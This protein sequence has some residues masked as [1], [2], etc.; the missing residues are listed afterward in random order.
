MVLIKKKKNSIYEWLDNPIQDLIILSDQQINIPTVVSKPV[1]IKA[2]KP[3][4]TKNII[5]PRAGTRS[6]SIKDAIEGKQS[7]VSKTES[8]ADND[9]DDDIDDDIELDFH[10]E[11]PIPITQIDIE[12]SWQLFI[13]EFLSTKPRYASLLS[14]YMPIVGEDSVVTVDLESQL[15]LDMFNEVK[16][17]LVLFLRKK[18]NNKLINIEPSIQE[19]DSTKNKLYTVEDKFKYLSELNPNII[20]LKQQ[21]NLDFD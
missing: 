1:E 15:Q 7:S 8:I 3:Q 17:D 18:Y 20:K 14:T 2:E 21:L 6:I 10:S 19:A 11:D 13:N 16:G 4:S 9:Q 5:P 12:N